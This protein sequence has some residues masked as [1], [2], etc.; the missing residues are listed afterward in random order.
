MAWTEPGKDKQP[1]QPNGSND[2][3]QGPP[4]LDKV[5]KEFSQKF[6][7]LFGKKK[8][9]SSTDKTP[10][11]GHSTVM[12]VG[13]VIAILIV[14]WILSGIFI[15]SPPEQAVVLRFGQYETTVGPGPHWIPRFIDSETI[16][17]VQQVSTYSYEAQMLTKD[18]NIVDVSVAVQYKIADAK[19][20]LFNV[21]DPEQSLQQATASALRQVI[22][23][24]NLDDILTS[25]RAVVR[26]EV[27]QQLNQILPIY[28][29]GIVVTDVA[30]QPAKAPDQVKDAFD[31]AIKAQEDEQ[32]YINQAQ[33]Y[34]Q[35]VVPVAQGNAQ[36]IL[37][38]A[39]AYRQQIVLAAKADVARYLAILPVYQSAPGVTRERMYLSMVQDVFQHTNKVLL[40]AKGNQNVVYLPL[41][42]LG[43]AAAPVA[44]STNA[45]PIT[46][47]ASDASQQSSTAPSYSSNTNSS[48]SN[49]AGAGRPQRF[50]FT[51]PDSQVGTGG[52]Q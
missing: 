42:K 40:D 11:S 31:D 5:F 51:N 3:N 47:A 13:I 2:P 7:S 28:N 4:D 49:A 24:T 39:Q 29:T 22:G 8:T 26:D 45:T 17:N 16:L 21:A 44:T 9:T 32:R 19:A 10:P 35:S 41:D 34:A 38:E 15:V 1:N 14:I 46:N 48:S 12:G 27:G 36:R 52:N 25:G 33:A 30:L 6:A 18:Q 50:V 37:Q 23:N 20:Y 43:A